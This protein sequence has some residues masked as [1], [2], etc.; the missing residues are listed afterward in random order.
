MI[1]IRLRPGKEIHSLMT[2]LHPGINCYCHFCGSPLR[3]QIARAGETVNCFNCCMETVLFIPG[4]QAPYS[5]QACILEARDIR[6]DESRFGIRH[7]QGY[8]ENK[9]PKRLNWV[10]IEFILFGKQ[11][12]VGSTSDCLIDVPPA[13]LWKFQAPVSQ[14]EAVHSSAPL[15]ACEYGRIQLSDTPLPP[16]NDVIPPVP[17]FST[18]SRKH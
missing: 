15:L 2:M 17:H 13:K 4:L 14:S 3:F 11:G 16:R 18:V 12:P 9:S 10:R 6:W 7:V 8:V 5:D 1:E